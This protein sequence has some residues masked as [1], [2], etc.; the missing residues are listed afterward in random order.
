MD[1]HSY[2]SLPQECKSEK[3]SPRATH[4]HA[5]SMAI[6]NK[7]I[8]SETTFRAQA[9][10]DVRK[11]HQ[12]VLCRSS[13]GFFPKH[14]LS[15]ENAAHLTIKDE[16]STVSSWGFNCSA[17][18]T[19]MSHSQITMVCSPFPVMGGLWHCYTHIGYVR[20]YQSVNHHYQSLLVTIS[21]Y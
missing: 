18:I 15:A 19:I 1:V 16:R 5:R 4:K 3:K 12:A 9:A 21:H 13:E 10:C 20:H 17:G 7:S 14:T 2:V 8:N 6:T 11:S